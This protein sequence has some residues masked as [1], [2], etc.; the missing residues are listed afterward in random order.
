MRLDLLRYGPVRAL[1]A[2]RWP[3][4]L[5]RATALGILLVAIVAGWFGTPV[6]NRNLSIVLVWVAWWAVLVLLAVPLLGRGWCAVCPVPMPGEWLQHGGVLGPRSGARGW[7]LGRRWPRPLRNTWLQTAAFL[8]LAL[9]ATV[10]L[11]QPRVTAAL[12]ASLLAL[13]AA[14]SLLFERRAFC[15]HLCPVGGFIGL[16]ARTAPLALRVR[17]V[18][19]CAGHET[20]TCVTGSAQGYGCPWSAFP[21]ALASNADCGLCMECVQTCPHDNIGLVLQAPGHDLSAARGRR[22]DEAVKALVLLGSA[23]AYSA[24][25]LGP[26]PALK[27]VAADIGS[28]GWF[29]FGAAFLVLVLGVVPGALWLAVRAGGALARSSEPAQRAFVRFAYAVIPLGL[30]AWAAFT[31]SLVLVNGSYLVAVLSDPLGWGWNLLGT[32]GAAWSPILTSFL[33]GLQAL[34]LLVGLTWSTLLASRVATE[35]GAVRAIGQAAPVVLLLL[36][37]TIA[38]L[39]LLIG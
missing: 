5:L 12:L 25:M 18:A 27:A 4:L 24:V 26:W 20:K 38:L 32:T 15:R 2:S 19:I 36:I 11:T 1:V 37:M 13:A 28:T 34:L 3:L 29:A 35:N 17:D 23:A 14:I 7:S 21:A 31:L 9:C 39:W 33:P 30:A 6:G 22:L 8:A 16:N 10:V